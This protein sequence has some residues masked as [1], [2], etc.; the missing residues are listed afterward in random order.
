MQTSCRAYSKRKVSSFQHTVG[1]RTGPKAS[2]I[3]HVNVEADQLVG[4]IAFALCQ[5][6]DIFVAQERQRNFI[7]LQIAAAGGV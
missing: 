6:S 1:E 2:A 7:K 5:R 4:V 3:E